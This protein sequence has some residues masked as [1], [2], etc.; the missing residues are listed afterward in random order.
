MHNQQQVASRRN[1]I[2]GFLAGGLGAMT[3][4]PRDIAA[5]L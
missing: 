1:F 3:I 2:K 5:A 4:S